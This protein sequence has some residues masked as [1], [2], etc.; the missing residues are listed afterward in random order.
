M[1]IFLFIVKFFF[2][3]ELLIFFRKCVLIKVVKSI[4][5]VNIFEDILE[6]LFLC[7]INDMKIELLVFYYFLLFWEYCIWLIDKTFFVVKKDYL[8]NGNYYLK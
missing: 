6:S 2:L 4:Y 3:I 8:K 5:L 1:V 7:L